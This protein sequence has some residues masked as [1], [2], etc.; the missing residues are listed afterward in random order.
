MGDH[1]VGD[2]DGEAGVLEGDELRFA[3]LTVDEDELVFLAEGRSEL[4]H[5]AAGDIGEVVFGFLAEE[6][7]FFDVEGDAKEAFDEGGGGALEGGRGGKPAAG[8]EVGNETGIEAGKRPVASVAKSFEDSAKVVGPFEVGNDLSFVEWD[9][10]FTITLSRE[11]TRLVGAIWRSG[12][13]DVAF[14]GEGE[15]EAVAVVDVLADEVD[16]AWGGG[17]ESSVSTI[18]LFEKISCV[19]DEGGEVF[20]GGEAHQFRGGKC[21]WKVR[22]GVALSRKE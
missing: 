12:D 7:F 6:R 3:R 14:D 21:V 2:E 1:G 10:G 8:G 22:Y 17:D 18:M 5:D 4:V 15:D 19:G 16:P 20:V 9:G 11:E 13:D